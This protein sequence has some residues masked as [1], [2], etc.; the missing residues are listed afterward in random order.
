[1]IDS[2]TC[3]EQYGIFDKNQELRRLRRFFEFIFWGRGYSS[4]MVPKFMRRPFGLS[5]IFR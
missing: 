4:D 1:M 5:V 3:V 2:E